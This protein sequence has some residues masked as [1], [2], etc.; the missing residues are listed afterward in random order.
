MGRSK[1][2]RYSTES[3]RLVKGAKIHLPNTSR[4]F[5]PKGLSILG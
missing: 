2:E 3:T 5:T 4:S 1:K